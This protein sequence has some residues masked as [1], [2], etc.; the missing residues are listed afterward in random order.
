MPPP[1]DKRRNALERNP[2]FLG[3]AGGDGDGASAFLISFAPD[4]AAREFDCSTF[5]LFGALAPLE[6][7][8]S[9]PAGAAFEFEEENLELRLVIHEFRL[10]T[11]PGF[12]S[13]E[14]LVGVEEA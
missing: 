7:S 8:F 12:E 10:P 14:F 9:A 1:E 3:D 13:L 4:G 11:E 5:G 2:G 6:T